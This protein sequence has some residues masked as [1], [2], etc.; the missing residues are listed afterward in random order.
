MAEAMPAWEQT[1]KAAQT[2]FIQPED[3]IQ[4]AHESV[5]HFY[6]QILTRGAIY[7]ITD[8]TPPPGTIEGH[9]KELAQQLDRYRG[10]EKEQAIE[11]ER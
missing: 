6:Q 8:H 9:F 7:Q 11:P 5:S 1:K 3:N 2:A 4:P 10:Q